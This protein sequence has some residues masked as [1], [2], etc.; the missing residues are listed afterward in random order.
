[1]NSDNLP[2]EDSLEIVTIYRSLYILKKKFEKYKDEISKIYTKYFIKDKKTIFDN[3]CCKIIKISSFK[4]L[5]EEICNIINITITKISTPKEL[6][7]L[8][9]MNQKKQNE[10]LKDSI[11]QIFYFITDKL[12]TYNDIFYNKKIKP[13]IELNTIESI[14]DDFTD[15]YPLAEYDKKGRLIFYYDQIK[16]LNKNYSYFQSNGF[17]LEKE[18]ELNKKENN[19]LYI[20]TLPLIIADFIQENPDYNIINNDFND[21]DLNNEVKSL[22]DGDIL[23]K[24]DMNNENEDNIKDLNEESLNDL[25]NQH[26]AIKNNIIMYNEILNDRKKTNYDLNY[27]QDFLKNLNIEKIKLEKKEIKNNRKIKFCSSKYGIIRRGKIPIKKRIKK[28]LLIIY[29]EKFKLALFLLLLIFQM[30]FYVLLIL[31]LIRKNLQNFLKIFH[32]KL[33]KR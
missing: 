10:K 4:S 24:M 25:Y 23:K 9:L 27:I 18:V 2:N 19:I 17:D 29:K 22:F 11:D 14:N 26:I 32:M 3:I 15:Y 21:Y 20:E 5:L 13:S 30:M 8:D 33:K 28:L 7:I 31:L 1:M 12:N 6:F 16:E